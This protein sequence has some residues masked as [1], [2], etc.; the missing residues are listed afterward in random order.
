MKKYFTVLSLIL[1]LFFLSSTFAKMNVLTIE[2]SPFVFYE[3]DK[4]T[5]FSI[6]LLKEIKQRSGIQYSLQVETSFSDMLE[7]IKDKKADAAIANISIT[8]EREKT[9]DFSHPIFDS[10]I[11]ML[12]RKP[13]SSFF[14]SSQ[15]KKVFLIFFILLLLS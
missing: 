15:A 11:Q 6:D 7:K 13:S 8:A 1:S 10:G 14:A 4:L 9:M 5:G 12:E 3:N 2:R